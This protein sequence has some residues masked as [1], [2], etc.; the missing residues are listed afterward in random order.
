MNY[1]RKNLLGLF[2]SL[3]LVI[4]TP[5]FGNEPNKLAPGEQQTMGSY[6]HNDGEDY[7]TMPGKSSSLYNN[8]RATTNKVTGNFTLPNGIKIKED[9]I[10]NTNNF[11]KTNN[12]QQY[13]VIHD[14]ANEASSA[15]AEAHRRYFQ[16]NDRR[17]SIHYVVDKDSGV[18]V[19][20]DNYS[21]YHVGDLNNT[22]AR[23]N[24]TTIGIELCVN[25]PKGS[26]G[27]AKVRENGA[28]LTKKLMS[29]YNIPASNVIMHK[30]CTGK[31]C[32]ARMIA[33]NYKEWNEFKKSIGTTALTETTYHK[34]GRVNSP[35]G[36]L[37]VRSQAN[38]SA[39]LIATLK[40]GQEVEVTHKVSNGWYK[41]K[42][43]DGKV[44]YA[45]GTYIS[46]IKDY[47]VYNGPK[48]GNTDLN[49][50]VDA[51][52]SSTLVINLPPNTKI[53]TVHGKK[54]ASNNVWWLKITALGKTGWVNS[55]YVEENV[56]VSALPDLAVKKN[57]TNQAVNLR[58]VPKYSGANTLVTIPKGTQI[59]DIKAKTSNGWVKVGYSGKVGYLAQEWLDNLDLNGIPTQDPVVKKPTI[60][61]ATNL[62]EN[63]DWKGNVILT[64]PA[65]KEVKV[66]GKTSGI[67]T[68]DP[69]VKKPTITVATNLRENPDWKGNVILTIP[70]DKEVKVTGKTSNGWYVVEHSGRVGF[71]NEDY[72]S[73]VGAVPVVN[74]PVGDVS[75]VNAAINIRDDKSWSSNTLVTVSSNEKLTVWENAAVP[76]VNKPV[77]DVSIV[78]AA[79]NIRDD[80]SWSSNTLVTVSSNEKLTVWENAGTDGWTKV[81]YKGYVGYVQDKYLDRVGQEVR[82]TVNVG[83]NEKLTVWENAG[84]DGWTKVNYKGYVGYV[85]DKYLDRVGQEVRGT[86]N[87]AVNLRESDSWGSTQFGVV[88]QGT[89]VIIVD[90]SNNEWVKVKV[91]SMNNKV[92]YINSKYITK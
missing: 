90:E 87:V 73:N 40:N 75:I 37:N 28:L 45:N 21:A 83:S 59:T 46:I 72:I 55:A 10:T 81:N 36:T 74:K 70:A 78:N 48:V 89:S 54:L 50:R 15:D 24:K 5:T 29:T 43:S 85:Q 18:H 92:G 69:V 3:A 51:D 1:K 56:N 22:S 67:P 27:W 52:V 84:T 66:T 2:L 62:R 33:N 4:P 8:S 20:Q 47:P 30:D 61:V 35:D 12:T 6:S 34:L 19:L 77:G 60:T 23:N 65:D 13:I 64:I 25:D 7:T 44:G 38:A 39:S 42:L 79:I 58:D 71:V 11:S 91:P 49:M 53:D 63:P 32:S 68:Q 82:G 41:L 14:T 26:S 88:T 17:V 76:V 86:V 9:Y 57:V 31:N 16:N 80:K